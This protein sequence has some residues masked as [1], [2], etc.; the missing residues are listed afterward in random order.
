MAFY[1]VY[2]DVTSVGLPGLPKP[3]QSD[4]Y[5]ATTDGLAIGIAKSILQQWGSD[6]ALWPG[7]WI[8]REVSAT[9]KHRSIR[10]V[11]TIT[12]AD[13]TAYTGPDF[14]TAT[15]E[16]GLTE[17]AALEDTWLSRNWRWLAAAAFVA[18]AVGIGY[19]LWTMRAPARVP[20]A[21]PTQE[22]L[23][24]QELAEDRAYEAAHKGNPC[25]EAPA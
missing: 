11:T 22:Q 4:W 13:V 15:T 16:S 2:Q 14:T 7:P 6:S 9:D 20:A 3:V 23:I 18:A 17:E 1:R 25:P 19:L 5:E 8:V 12:E 24:Q 10:D 21:T